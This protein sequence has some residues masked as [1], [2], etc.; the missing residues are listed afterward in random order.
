MVVCFQIMSNSPRSPSKIAAITNYKNFIKWSKRLHFILKWAEIY[1]VASQIV[2]C[3]Y[4]SSFYN[5]NGFLLH[6]QIR[7]IWTKFDLNI[8]ILEPYLFYKIVCV[9]IFGQSVRKTNIAAIAEH[10]MQ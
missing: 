1:N 8:L 3:S 9:F 7:S 5:L 6:I 10:R 4:N 2:S